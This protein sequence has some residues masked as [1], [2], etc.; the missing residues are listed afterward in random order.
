MFYIKKPENF[1]PKLNVVICYCIFEENILF[2]RRKKCKF[3]G[4]LWTAPGGKQEINENPFHAIKREL[5]EETNININIEELE[6]IGLFFIKNDFC[7]FT[8]QIF[9]INLN[10]KPQNIQLSIEEHDQY[11][12][13]TKEEILQMPL[14][15]D[16][17]QCLLTT[18][19]KEFA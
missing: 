19:Q 11:K 17:D 14:V 1:H 18:F 7:D 10:E 13:L 2:L 4:G 8:M 16:A 15:P 3:H 5:L 9:K 12:W 6:N